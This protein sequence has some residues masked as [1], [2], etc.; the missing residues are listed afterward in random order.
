MPGMKKYQGYKVADPKKALIQS[1]AKSAASKAKKP[2]VPAKAKKP[3]PSLSD[4]EM[5]KSEAIAK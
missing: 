5:K 1:K 2:T 4:S 3:S